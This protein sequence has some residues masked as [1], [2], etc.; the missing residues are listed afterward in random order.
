[1]IYEII[2]LP[3]QALQIAN[4]AI[5]VAFAGGLVDNVFVVVITQPTRQFLVVHLRLVFADAPASSNLT[6]KNHILEAYS[7]FCFLILISMHWREAQQRSLIR[8]RYYD[9]TN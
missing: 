8:V 2:C 1:M 5:D 6:S 4:K 3:E 7:P 9:S